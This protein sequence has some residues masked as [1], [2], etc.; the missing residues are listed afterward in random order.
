[1]KIDIRLLLLTFTF[2]FFPLSSKAAT[3][4]E[5][6]LH[7]TMKEDL[8]GNLEEGEYQ[9]VSLDNAVTRARCPYTC[10]DRGLPKKHCRTWKSVKDE[11]L[12]YVEDT[13][14]GSTPLPI[15]E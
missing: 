2:T 6:P 15:N 14:K 11:M 8:D 4:E 5:P 7:V 9:R 1:M 13:A 3:E 10:E 12:C